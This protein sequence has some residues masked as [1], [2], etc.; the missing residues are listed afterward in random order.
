MGAPR[1]LVVDDNKDMAQGVAMVLREAPAEVESAY[2]ADE[3]CAR[4]G[5][6]AF[7]LVVTDVRMPGQDGMQLLDVIVE[8]WPRSKVVM[9]TAYGTVQSAVEAMKR[10]A[11]DYVTKPFNNEELLL[12]VKRA[13]RE[14]QLEE[15]LQRL[16]AEFEGRYVFEGLVGRDAQMLGVF[17]AVRKVAPSHATVLVCGEHGTGKELVARAIH[18]LS[19]RKGPFVAFSAA[20]LPDTLIDAELFGARKGAF[21]GADHDRK[22]HFVEANDGTLFIDEVGSMPPL[23]Q[24]KLLRVLQEREV[25]PVGS[26]TPTKTDARVVAATN[27]DLLRATR[28]GRFRDDLYYRLSVV[29]VALPPLRDRIEDVPLLA[30]HFL[31]RRCSERGI[32]K[33]RLSHRATRVLLLH[34]WPG[35]VRELMNV[36]D[37]A[38]LFCQDDVVEPKHISFDEEAT[39]ADLSEPQSYEATKREVLERFQRL[40]VERLLH[41]CDGN[42]TEAARRAGLTR[43]AVHRMLKRLGIAAPHPEARRG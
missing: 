3:A 38:V 14:R 23:V 24:V 13:L 43:A 15:D 25:L 22:G 32:A 11:C 26:S 31:S 40:F 10:G 39:A 6:R 29:R 35:N 9:L 33:K 20:A 42:I 34:E 5:E 1:I 37:R 8:R 17:D 27:T 2:T 4:L 12:V 21:T 16:Q 18:R 30:E 36:I 19:G 41:E 7:D 28:E